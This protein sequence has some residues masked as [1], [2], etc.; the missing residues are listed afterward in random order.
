MK[1]PGSVALQDVAERTTEL[2]VAC[3]RCERRGKYA[4]ARLVAKFGPDFPMTELGAVLANCPRKNAPVYER[5]D[6]YF[7]HLAELMN[8]PTD[9]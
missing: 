8:P 1:R 2:E 6:V 4:T 3:S 5:C 9:P 7:P